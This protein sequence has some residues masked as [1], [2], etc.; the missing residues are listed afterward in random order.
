[1]NQKKCPKCGEMNPA[2]AVMCWACYTPLT[3]GAPVAAGAGGAGALAQPNAPSASNDDN[4]KSIAPWQIGVLAVALL[5]GLGFGVSSMMGGGS[6]GDSS[7]GGSGGIEI[8]PPSSSSSGGG[9]GGGSVAPGAVAPPISSSGGGGEIKPAAAPFSIVTAPNPALQWGI[10]SI[11]P[12]QPNVSPQKAAS[13]AAFA[14]RQFKRNS[15]W[16][17]LQ[18][19]VFQNME[20]AQAFKVYQTGRRQDVLGPGDYTALANIWPQCLARYEINGTR[21]TVKLPS[22][23]PTSWWR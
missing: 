16:R 7:Q 1:V 14:G 5:I 11:V 9:G 4:K 12:T 15:E 19:Y 6:V 21:E 23:A 18:V 10:M 2:E 13:L 3:G 17:A 22:S 20:A 8:S